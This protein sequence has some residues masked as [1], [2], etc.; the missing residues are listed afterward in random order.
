MS[1]FLV[2]CFGDCFQ[3]EMENDSSLERTTVRGVCSVVAVPLWFVSFG[4][5][6]RWICRQVRLP[7]ALRS[8]V[9]IHLVGSANGHRR[10]IR[11]SP[12]MDDAFDGDGGDGDD[13]S[14]VP[15]GTGTN[16]ADSRR[17]LCR[18]SLCEHFRKLVGGRNLAG[19]QVPVRKPFFSY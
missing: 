8:D 7:V 14:I 19:T 17:H 16:V 1:R 15:T 5:R 2:G 10:K 6:Q 18:F 4:L 12:P 13:V 11:Q 9:R 3:R